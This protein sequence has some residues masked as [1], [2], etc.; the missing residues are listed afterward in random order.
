VEQVQA[1]LQRPDSAALLGGAQALV[2][3]G[4][5]VFERPAPDTALLRSLWLLLPTSTR[6]DLWPASFAF[7]NDLGFDVL[8]VPRAAGEA[9]D[10]YLTEEQAAEYPEGRYEL[11]LQIAAEAGDQRELDTLFAR[12]S[13]AE[14]W[15]LGLM[16]LVVL[17][18]LLAVMGWL[19][20]AHPEPQPAPPAPAP[21]KLALPPADHYPQ[22][23][24][25]ERQQLTEDLQ[26]LAKRLGETPPPT[27]T[28][29][30]LLD[31]IDQRLGTPD[32]RRDPG[33]IRNWGPP[34][35]QL[36]ALLWKQGVEEYHDERLNPFELVERLEEK[37]IDKVPRGRSPRD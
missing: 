33:P 35:R 12:R 28:V 32:P 2:D 16:L 8:V 26:A 6:T 34:K 27:A 14:T 23:N 25:R 20:V 5:V 17:A 21:L 29:E 30:Q 4:R 19:K 11:S 1:V 9:F 24:P 22:L 3:G 37:V 10:G 31:T 15:R 36:Q 7:G 13:A 18:V